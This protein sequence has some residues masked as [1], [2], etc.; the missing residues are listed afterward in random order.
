MFE[1]VQG[2]D[3]LAAGAGRVGGK[4]FSVCGP[5]NRLAPQKLEEELRTFGDASAEEPKRKRPEDKTVMAVADPAGPH[6]TDRCIYPLVD[7]KVQQYGT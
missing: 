1:A 3:L 4:A 5:I 6:R 7:A 2:A